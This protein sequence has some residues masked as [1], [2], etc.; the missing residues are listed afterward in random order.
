MDFAASYLHTH[1]H[2]SSAITILADNLHQYPTS[3]RDYANNYLLAIKEIY[4]FLY[5]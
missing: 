5:Q 1:T 2:T 4:H 3:A